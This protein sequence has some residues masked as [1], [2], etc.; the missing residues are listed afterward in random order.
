VHNE[1]VESDATGRVDDVSKEQALQFGWYSE[2]ASLAISTAKW[3]GLG[4]LAGLCVGA[5]TKLFLFCLS[6]A[7]SYAERLDF[8]EFHPYYLLPLALPLCVF[9][10][11]KFAPTA[12]GHGTEAVIEAVHSHSGHIQPAVAPIKLFATV[13]TLAFWRIGR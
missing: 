2:H 1:R 8:K 13:L 3:G 10:I 9:L 11:R 12:K 6:W 5:G 7:T 4:A